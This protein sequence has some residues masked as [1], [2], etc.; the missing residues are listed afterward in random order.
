MREQ[1]ERLGIEAAGVDQ[2]ARQLMPDDLL[3]HAADLDQS[4]EIDAGI[5]AHLF[6]EQHQ[7]LGADIAGCFWLA[8]ERAVAESADR[9]VELGNAHLEPGMCVGD[10]EPARIVEVQRDRD[11]GPAA[12]HIAQ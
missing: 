12:A 6:A 2:L 10:G 11:V 8:G 5:D 7:F 1:N 4:I 3:G 9:R